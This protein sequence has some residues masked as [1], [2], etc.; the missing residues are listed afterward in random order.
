M[1]VR[2]MSRVFGMINEFSDA[3]GTGNF[4]C[5]FVELHYDHLGEEGRMQARQPGT[6]V[7]IFSDTPFALQRV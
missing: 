1:C 3:L 2:R 7:W 5:E 4:V 6:D